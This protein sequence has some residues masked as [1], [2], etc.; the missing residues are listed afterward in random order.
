MENHHDIE[1]KEGLSVFVILVL[2]GLAAIIG[3]TM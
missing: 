1:D 2:M 3:L